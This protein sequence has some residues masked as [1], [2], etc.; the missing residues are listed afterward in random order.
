[1]VQVNTLTTRGHRKW[2]ASFETKVN[3][4]NTGGTI[5]IISFKKTLANVS[6]MINLKY[7][8]VV[9]SCWNMLDSNLVRKGT[10]I[11]GD[12][13]SKA[14]ASNLFTHVLAGEP[15]HARHL[16]QS[17]LSTQTTMWLHIRLQ[18]N[19]LNLVWWYQIKQANTATKIGQG[20]NIQIPQ[21]RGKKTKATTYSGKPQAKSPDKSNPCACERPL[22]QHPLQT[23]HE[24]TGTLKTARAF[25]EKEQKQPTTTTSLPELIPGFHLRPEDSWQKRCH[26]SLA[27]GH[28]HFHFL[29][30]LL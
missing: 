15:Q 12:P 11:Y 25:E 4:A 22:W 16:H 10:I 29:L 17:T 14:Q 6:F 26:W 27:T 13:K 5:S 30:M 9:A 19:L 2:P 3:S 1:M 18:Q 20:P 28:T 24:L 7:K 21:K 8:Q 23:T